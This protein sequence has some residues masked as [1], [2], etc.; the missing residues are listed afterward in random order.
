MKTKTSIMLISRLIYHILKI[1]VRSLIHKSILVFN[2]E[3]STQGFL[4]AIKHIKQMRL[5][6]TRYI[7]GKPL[8]TNDVYVSLDKTGWPTRLSHLKPLTKSIIG[9]RALMTI[10]TFTKSWTPKS[11]ERKRMSPDYSSI[12]KESIVSSPYTIPIWFIK[13]FVSVH[14]MQ[15]K[16]PL[17]TDRDHYISTKMSPNGPSTISSIW[18]WQSLEPKTI[19]SIKFFLAG[20]WNYFTDWW[21]K[22]KDLPVKG[23]IK[24]GLSGKLAIRE[25]PEGK[26]RV[27][28]MVDYHSQFVLRRLHKELFSLLKLL[29][30]DR[31]TTQDPFHKW[32]DN[33]EYF[34]SL[35]LSNAT[36]RFPIDLQ[37]KLLSVIYNNRLYADHWKQLLVSRAYYDPQG[38]KHFYSVGQPMGAYSSWVMFTLTHHLV[39]SWAAHLSGYDPFT[40]DQYI[41]LGDD[42]VIKNQRIA[43]RYTNI[44]TKLGVSISKQKTH[45]SKDTYEFAKRWIKGGIEITGIPLRG[46][47]S[48]LELVSIYNTISVYR[49]RVCAVGDTTMATIGAVLHKVT[50]NFLSRKF[51]L[52]KQEIMNLAQDLHALM[53][54]NNNSPYDE[55]REYLALKLKDSDLVIPPERLIRKYLRALFSEIMSSK[56]MMFSLKSRNQIHKLKKVIET[57]LGITDIEKL[58]VVE[59]LISSMTSV[60]E[61]LKRSKADDFDL[62]EESLIINQPE[63]DKIVKLFRDP[64]QTLTNACSIWRMMFKVMREGLIDE[65]QYEASLAQVHHY[66]TNDGT[67]EMAQPGYDLVW[68]EDAWWKLII[69]DFETY[70]DSN[71]NTCL[72][73]IFENDINKNV[74]KVATP[75]F[76]PLI[77]QSTS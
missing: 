4:H 37:G 31:T 66:I 58:P 63:P 50:F 18:S 73:T 27:I 74:N 62:I 29:P 38:N 49:N 59:G 23:K 48:N 53:R 45:V 20:Q 70:K 76:S 5:H 72:K 44:I 32:E 11:K 42:I 13:E 77:Y 46:I 28:A 3:R 39:V 14:K 24:L 64:T 12:D 67:D 43:Q 10:M 57:D 55:L 35:D 54:F 36:D 34:Y 60:I 69:M 26:L 40:F 52:P 47:L 19:E 51:Y 1:D 22:L 68:D 25:D 71:W 15:L 2:N 41:I 21:E 65:T 16:E 9:L 30:C 8:L 75:F 61:R 7:C 17:Y 33:R 56:V 6:I